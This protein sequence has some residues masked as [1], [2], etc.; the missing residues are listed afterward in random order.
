[1]GRGELVEPVALGVGIGDR[2][3]A[4]LGHHPQRLLVACALA[5]AVGCGARGLGGTFALFAGTLLAGAAPGVVGV[6]AA[7]GELGE[8]Q[9]ARATKDNRAIPVRRISVPFPG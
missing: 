4:R 3:A 8:L 7:E 2:Q 5:T 6:G 9:A 1:M